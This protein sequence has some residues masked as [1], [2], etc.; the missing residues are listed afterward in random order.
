LLNLVPV[1][2]GA[3]AVS[4]GFGLERLVEKQIMEISD[5]ANLQP[6]ITNQILSFS[7]GLPEQTKGGL[8]AG[9]VAILHLWTV[10][11]ILGKH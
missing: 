8:I 5:K 2:A 11:S 1:V 3:F 4:K 10:K 6:N 9:L 7:P